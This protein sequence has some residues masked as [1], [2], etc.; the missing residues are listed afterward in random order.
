MSK[1]QDQGYWKSLIYYRIS[2]INY[3]IQSAIHWN[4]TWYE[5]ANPAIEHGGMLNEKKSAIYPLLNQ[6]YLPKTKYFTHNTD[7]K[8]FLNKHNFQYPLIIKPDVGLKGIEVTKVVSVEEV[9]MELS[10]VDERGLIVQEY[11]D[12]PREY[13]VLYYIFDNGTYGISSLI[14]K[15]YPVVIGDGSRDIYTLID[16]YPHAYLNKEDV[17]KLHQNRVLAIGEKLILHHIGNYSRGSTFHSLMNEI[18]DRLASAV[19]N[20]LKTSE[21]ISFGRLDIK[22][23]DIEAVR[24]GDFKII[25]F[26][27]GKSEPLHIYDKNISYIETF[28]IV[29]NHWKIYN[30]IATE[31]LLK[32]FKTISTKEGVIALKK[33]KKV[34]KRKR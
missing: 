26:N 7:I 28:K 23:V 2:V 18:D 11:I 16:E 21:G 12:L 22:A 25:E 3:W 29:F 33:I 13:S 17:K 34:T 27:G 32:G 24:N 8:G 5:A 31:R 15:K 9:I 19:H 20:C 1:W 6:S 14:E 10:N 30:K 4:Y